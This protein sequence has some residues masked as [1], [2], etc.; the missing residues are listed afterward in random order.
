MER[1]D[2]DQAARDAWHTD[3]AAFIGGKEVPYDSQTKAS[4]QD[5]AEPP[6][7]VEAD[8]CL[9]N[10]GAAR[11]TIPINDHLFVDVDDQRHILGVESL[12]G[13]L[14]ESELIEVLKRC[15]LPSGEGTE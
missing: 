15:V 5:I 6:F 1:L 8:R 9:V 12:G 10:A 14:A 2:C 11:T 4:Y 13:P 7:V 3:H